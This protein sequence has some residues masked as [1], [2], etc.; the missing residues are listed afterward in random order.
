[1]AQGNKGRKNHPVRSCATTISVKFNE[2]ASKMTGKIKRHKETS[3]EIIC[4][5]KGK[6]PKKAYFEL[7]AQPAIIIP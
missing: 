5:A 7:L 6:E 3:Y 4:E 2:P 1:M